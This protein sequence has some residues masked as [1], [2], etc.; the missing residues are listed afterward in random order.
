MSVKANLGHGLFST[1]VS[2]G[3]RAGRTVYFARIWIPSEARARYFALRETTEPQARKRLGAL[4]VDP[5]KA[6]REHLAKKAA[7]HAPPELV[8]K[9]LVQ[10]FLAGYKSKG[11]SGY[12][13]NAS[14]AWVRHLGEV[15]AAKVTRAMMEDFREALR[16]DIRS[17]HRRPYGD[18]AIRKYVGNVGTMYRWAK[19]RG[20]LADDPILG[21][22]R[23]G[24]GI[25]RPAEPDRLVGVLSR[26][27]EKKLLEA[28]DDQTRLVIRLFIESGM[29]QGETDHDTE[30]FTLRWGQVQEDKILIHKSKTSRART[31]P[32]NQR[33]RAALD[34]CLGNLRS[35]IL[36]AD[37][38][39]GKAPQAYVLSDPQGEPL[40]ADKVWRC[41]ESAMQRAKI[42]KP[43]GSRYNLFRHTFGSRLAEQGVHFG[44]IAK[45]MGNSAATCEKHYIDFSPGH[46]HAAMATLDAPTVTRRRRPRTVTQT[47]TRGEKRRQT[48]S[49]NRMEVV[50]G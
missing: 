2:T 10:Q 4:G 23:K 5:E 40:N 1:T 19:G 47:V 22:S 43:A 39:S 27:D 13:K 20:I 45:I 44:V 33:V 26:E 9:D 8:F 32:I 35:D 29:R 3:P 48:S 46:L 14:K 11:N 7:R 36:R 24:E 34:D 28:A 12:Y 16:R 50:A 18:S 17:R 15:P 37:I 38:Q 6:L 21:W 25:S 49:E 41:I 30:A 42:V 31:I